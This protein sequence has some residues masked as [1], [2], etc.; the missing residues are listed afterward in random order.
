MTS[1]ACGSDEAAPWAAAG[2]AITVELGDG[3]AGAV[4]PTG[5]A[6]AKTGPAQSTPDGH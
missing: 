5:D 4:E 1:F 6:A 3:E 2:V